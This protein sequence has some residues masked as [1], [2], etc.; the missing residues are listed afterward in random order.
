MITYIK[1]NGFKSF[2]NFEMDF[3]PL[4]II[5]GTNA[6]GKSNL[7]DALILLSSL[8]ETDNI[9]KAFRNQRGEFIELFTQYGE[10][11]YAREM[12]FCIEMLVNK[13]VTDAWGNSAVLKYTRLRYELK[14]KRYTNDSGL[15]DIELSY[16]SLV[17]LKHN[18]DKWIEVIPAEYRENWRPK[19]ITDIRTMPYIETIKE[20]DKLTV[21]ILQDGLSDTKRKSYPINKAFRTMLS[22]FDTIEFPHALAAKEE[23]KSWQFLQL[24]PEDLRKP[25]DKSDGEDT[26]SKSGKNLAAALNRIAFKN[27]YS[28]DEISRKLQAFVPNFVE[29]KVIDDKEKNQFIVKVID[30]DGKEYTSRVLSEG[31][32][33]ILALCILEQDDRH[34]GL[35]CF[36]EP[37]NGVH[38]FRIPT[39]TTLLKNLTNDFTDE[40]LALRQVIVNT[41]SPI[42]VKEIY[43]WENDRNVS[44]WYA[45]MVNRVTD[46]DGIRMKLSVTDINKVEK[47]LTYQLNIFIPDDQRKMTLAKIQE[48]L[49]T[50]GN[51]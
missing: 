15:E 3:T 43:K 1:I 44:I 22:S 16:E 25:T 4:T 17:N 13:N 20:G 48:Y 31:T 5:A 35:L 21:E 19:V 45:A 18:K 33:R 34:T 2:N 46:I 42:F 51:L 23:M 10:N 47:D 50:T 29:V 9:K 30:K 8:A 24:N 12:E 36:E 40:E 37:E 6:A 41:H 26:I 7:F 28:L 11:N 49:T 38:P 39:M 14:I 27:K 32:L